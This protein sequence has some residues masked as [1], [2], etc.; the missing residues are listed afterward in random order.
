MTA[1]F[2]PEKYVDNEHMQKYI[3]TFIIILCVFKQ[4]EY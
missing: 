2:L 3:L 1:I 4:S